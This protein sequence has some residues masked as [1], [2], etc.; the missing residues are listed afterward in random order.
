MKPSN[1]YHYIYQPLW[2]VPFG[3]GVLAFQNFIYYMTFEVVAPRYQ[4]LEAALQHVSTVDEVSPETKMHVAL[5]CFLTASP[6]CSTIQSSN[7][8]ET[9]KTTKHAARIITFS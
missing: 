2:A 8:H 4:A 9:T 6:L 1:Q 3:C 5:R 7:A